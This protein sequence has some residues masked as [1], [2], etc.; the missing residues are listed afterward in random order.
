[1]PQMQF[2]F[3]GLIQLVADHLY[4]EK[5]VFI[6]E[7]VQN[8]HDAVKRRAKVDKG[9]YGGRIDIETRPSERRI[10]FRD[11]GIGMNRDD[12]E[13]YLSNIGKSFTR[14]QQEEVEGLI[15]EFG[16]GFLAGFVVASRVEVRTRKFGEAQGWLWENEGSR[17]YSLTPCDVPAPGTTVTVFIRGEA[18]KGVIHEDQVREVIRHYA[19]MLLVPI[20]LNGG[21][22]PV[23]T[24]HMPWEKTG[25]NPE[26]LQMDCFLY[27]EKTMR[28]S[29]LEA[30]PIQLSGKVNAQ[31]VLYIT[32]TRTVGI[33]SPRTVHLF[34]K[35]MFLREN[36]TEILPRW[37]SFVNGVINTSDLKPTAARDNFVRNDAASDYVR[38]DAASDL[39]DALGDLVIRHLDDL[40]A[41]NSERFSQILRYH[42]LGIKAA[43]HY[44]RDT[45]FK[46]FAHLLEWRTNSKERDDL[47][48]DYKAAWRTLPQILDRQEG[49]PQRLPCFTTRNSA[50]QYFQM[51][52]AVDSIVVD[53]SYPFESEL[54]EAYSK[55]DGIN[56][57]LVRVD[58]EDDPNVFCHLKGD[59]DAPVRHLADFMAQVIRP[60]GR[61]RIRVDA[62]RFKPAELAA[63]IRS[64]PRSRGL[65][66]AEQILNDPN[67]SQD[68]REMAEEM[69]SLARYESMKLT[70]NADN[71]LVLRLARQKLENT[72]VIEIMT[73][74]YNNAILVNQ[75]LMTP[76]NAQI[77]HDQ[78]QKL[79][80]RSLDFLDARSGLEK[81]RDQLMQERARAQARCGPQPRHRIFFMMT[82]FADDYKLLVQ[83]L[84]EVV[85]DRWGCQLFVA[86]DRQY[87]LRILDNVRLHMDQA[88]ALIA[89]VS[90]A[91]PNVMFELGAALS[92]R[93][94]RPFVLLHN[95]AGDPKRGLP[96]DLG[97]LI[98]LDY[99]DTGESSLQDY[100]AEKMGTNMELK[101]LLDDAK[102][103]QYLSHRELKRLSR[104]S[105]LPDAVFQ[106][107]S[108]LY[109]TH[110]IWKSLQPD[111]LKPHL[112]REDDL[113]KTIIGRIVGKS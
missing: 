65:G 61:G 18:D 22:N 39:R 54:I 29:V 72:D 4:S 105:H 49:E 23:N 19:D 16:I 37:A 75:E 93:R 103:E 36:A 86:S 50:N 97:G 111:D 6:R 77:F 2:D 88:H 42:D 48:G 9:G 40:H 104:F 10:I 109:P 68:L 43:C 8:A 92:D 64:D 53:A 57:R 101:G 33:D 106:R 5:K 56:V 73:G 112:G 15:G 3:D 11:N 100:L 79:M 99:Y 58:R 60:G 24:M 55:L 45:F 28:D 66:K 108:E 26:E 107:L 87:E 35:R 94:G 38:N 25:I 34:L 46:K 14:M 41:R 51:A 20:H 83:T 13:D 27:L 81:E 89:E 70:I 69:A 82:P 95:G 12:L 113:A 102:W 30:I 71:S 74:I 98:Y 32:R 17:D 47:S 90:E 80:E 21:G 1:M 31:G 96:A 85:E 84:R 110:E 63:V 78:F 91:N 52:N 62:R 7:L 76:Q 59:E 67:A 44:Y